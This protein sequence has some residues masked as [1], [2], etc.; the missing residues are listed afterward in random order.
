MSSSRLTDPPG[1]LSFTATAPASP[2][3]VGL[4]GIGRSISV[5]GSLY[6]KSI[7]GRLARRNLRAERYA[8]GSSSIAGTAEAERSDST[9]A[10]ETEPEPAASQRR[11]TTQ[12]RKKKLKPGRF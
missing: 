6:R 12:K 8:S 1:R 3:Q 2:S 9:A 10:T 7:R 4:R 11:E 5:V